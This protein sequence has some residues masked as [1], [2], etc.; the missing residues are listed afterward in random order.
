MEIA[1]L[2][3]WG[4]EVF[5]LLGRYLK[6]LLRQEKGK[7]IKPEVYFVE[8]VLIYTYI[9]GHSLLKTDPT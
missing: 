2:L 9:V 8:V 3:D 7:K 6:Y 4:S 1:S 5:K